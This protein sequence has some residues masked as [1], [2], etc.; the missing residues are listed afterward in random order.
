M[1]PKLPSDMPPE[2]QID[3][4]LLAILQQ[5]Q[6]SG[7]TA[8]EDPPVYQSG[9][10]WDPQHSTDPNSETRQY[11]NS[12]SQKPL[13]KALLDFY[14]LDDKELRRFQELAFQAGLYGSSAERGDIPFGAK[15]DRTFAIWQSYNERAANMFK[16][17]KKNTVWDLL[18]DDVAHRPENANKNKKRAPLITQLPDPRDIEEMVRGVAPSV[19][20]RDADP[21]FIADFQAMYARIVSQFQENKYALE[22]TEQGG[23]ITAPPSAE[24]L[25]AFRLRTENPEQYEE[26]RAAAR[27]QAYTNLLKAA[28]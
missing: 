28:L 13:S 18:N 24:A 14:S 7:Y 9:Y 8:K 17:G 22:G 5:G 16:V 12:P 27:Q 1:A 26:K 20:G 15:D 6:N 3:P 10:W 4:N 2:A 19:I 25:A 23:T 11:V 21:E